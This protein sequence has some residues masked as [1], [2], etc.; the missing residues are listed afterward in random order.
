MIISRV[1]PCCCKQHYFILFYGW[2]INSMVLAQKQTYR[3]ME[4]NR[5]P[6][7]KPTHLR[8][9]G[10][11]G[12]RPPSRRWAADKRAKLHLGLPVAPHHSHYHLN[13]APTPPRSME[14]LSSTKPLPCA[15]KVGNRWVNLWQRKRDYTMEKDSL[16][17]K[18]CWENWTATRKRIKLE[19]SLT[20][21]TKINSKW[22]KDLNVKPET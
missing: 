15:K 17:S 9:L 22:I 19:H 10:L 6:R 11:L 18:W 13:C 8:C 12:T 5:K 7:N 20:P 14:K 1:H 2:V 21:Y 3:S 16:F 4:Q